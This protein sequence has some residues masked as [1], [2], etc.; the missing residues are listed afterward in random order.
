MAKQKAV[1]SAILDVNSAIYYNL[2]NCPDC[3]DFYGEEYK[4]DS[5]GITFTYNANT[6]RNFN[7]RITSGD[8]GSGIYAY[9]TKKKEWVLLGVTS[10]STTG[11]VAYIAAV[12]N[13]D[14]LNFQQQF[15]QKINLKIQD[16]ADA[17]TWTLK[18]NDLTY[19]RRGDAPNGSY[20]LQNNK[21]LIFS[22][23][24]TIEV[25]GNINRNTS[26]YAG[27]FVFEASSGASS[28]NPTKY[29]F[30]NANGQTYSF[31]GSGLDIGENV[32]VEWHLRNGEIKNN[33][34]TT[35]DSLIK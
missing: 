18:G 22:G 20:I 14:L 29:T 27:G 7:N 10:Q 21:D 1:D 34:K 16:H 2:V 9:N 6:E 17:N 31:I 15:E 28:T 30:T 32:V 33:D 11:N 4:P 24:G 26:G 35:Y 12:S 3:P 13:K 25:Q 5:R 23:G 19:Q 8:S